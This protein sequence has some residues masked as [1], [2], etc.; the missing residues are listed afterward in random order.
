LA[1]FNDNTG[2]IIKKWTA[3]VSNGRS[4]APYFFFINLITG[5]AHRRS[6]GGLKSACAHAP[7]FECA[8]AGESG[9]LFTTIPAVLIAFQQQ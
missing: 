2:E 5:P 1:F 7:A 4:S 3:K 8:S 6:E 9:K